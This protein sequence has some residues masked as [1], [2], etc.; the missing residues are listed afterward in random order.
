MPRPHHNVIRFSTSHAEPGG[1]TD[2]RGGPLLRAKDDA[3]VVF[4][5][6]MGGVGMQGIMWRRLETSGAIS[7]VAAGVGSPPAQSLAPIAKRRS[8]GTNRLTRAVLLGV[9]PIAQ[10]RTE[11]A[12]EAEGVA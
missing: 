9:F 12:I 4:T 2:G 6:I 3:G 11:D 1:S 10:P 5:A 8:A 7:P